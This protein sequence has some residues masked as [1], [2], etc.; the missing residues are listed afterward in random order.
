[1]LLCDRKTFLA[2]CGILAFLAAA[3]EVFIGN[4]RS[5]PGMNIILGAAG[6]LSLVLLGNF[7]LRPLL[8]RAEDYYGGGEDDE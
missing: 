8:Q 3:L 2:F 6:C 5:I 1:M 7:V 4:G